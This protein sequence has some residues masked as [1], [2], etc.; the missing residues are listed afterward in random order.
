MAGVTSSTLQGTD[1]PLADLYDVALLDLDGVVYVGPAAVPGAPEALANARAHGMR[2]AFVTNNAARPPEVVA[3]H[4]TALGIPADSSEV[5]TSSQAA[6][7]YLADRFPAG[8]PVLVVGTVG[9]Y[10]ALAERGLRPVG[11]ADEKPV[12]VAQGYSPTLSWADL[13]EG[14][15]AIGQ[16]ALWVATNVDPT[17]PSP[18]G[19][20]PGNGSLVEALKHATGAVP[21]VTGKPDPTMHRE[22]VERSGAERPIVVGDRLDTDIEGAN[23]VGCPSLL[24]LSGVTLA[25]DLIAAA[26]RERPNYLGRDLAA[27]L[28]AHPAPSLTDD[29]AELGRWSVRVDGDRLLLDHDAGQL[30][31]AVES[32]DGLDA[33]RV[34]SAAAWQAATG[35]AGD[36]GCAAGS[37]TAAAALS[38][39]GLS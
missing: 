14:A 12:A 1:V 27:L 25:A 37:Q 30:D 35:E 17:V 16:G 36:F 11:S 26:P 29:G 7:H 32:P 28:Y 13:A 22:S 10:E 19:P 31:G 38:A 18:R 33:L 23:A 15:V 8:S 5:T 3:E 34:L 39:L 21:I 20:L 6:A 4:L 2:L 24:V 9:L